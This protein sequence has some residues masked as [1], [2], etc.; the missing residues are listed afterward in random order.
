MKAIEAFCELEQNVSETMTPYIHRCA[1]VR[2]VTIIGEF[3]HGVIINE[4]NKKQI[5]HNESIKIHKTLLIDAIRRQEQEWYY[6]GQDNLEKHIQAFAK[7]KDI[8][9]KSDVW[10]TF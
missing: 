2:L 4:T 1:I 6:A 8:I 5:E 3:F 7:S 9:D 10:Y